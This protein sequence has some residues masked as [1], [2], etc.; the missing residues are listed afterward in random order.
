MEE[1]NGHIFISSG[2]FHRLALDFSS[3]AYRS[4]VPR[5]PTPPTNRN[6]E[7]KEKAGGRKEGGGGGLRTSH[8]LLLYEGGGGGHRALFRS[9]GRRRYGCS[10]YAFE[11]TK[12]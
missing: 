4:S 6:Y 11:F 2:P 8:G 7:G 3:I 9:K 12:L 10:S 5:Q 1:G